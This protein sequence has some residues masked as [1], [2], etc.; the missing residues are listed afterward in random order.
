MNRRQFIASTVIGLFAAKVAATVKPKP[1]FNHW[2][3]PYVVDNSCR[4]WLTFPVRYESRFNP[5][6][7]V[8][9][10]VVDVDKEGRTV[11]FDTEIEG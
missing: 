11:T 4:N 5:G 8:T 7:L 6:A 9:F 10:Y 3:F 1:D 2:P